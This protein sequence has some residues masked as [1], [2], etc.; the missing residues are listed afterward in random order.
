MSI[1]EQ[2]WQRIYDSL[3]AYLQQFG[4]NDIC[5]AGEFWLVEDDWGGA[6]QKICIF[7]PK[8]LTQEFVRKLQAFMLDVAPDW[9]VIVAMDFPDIPMPENGMWLVVTGRDVQY[10][11]DL[12]ALRLLLS[13]PDF[14]SA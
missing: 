9:S 4:K 7:D 12:P 5:P 14:Y 11:W 13:M 3:F 10:H 1:R 6:Q 8:V 2:E